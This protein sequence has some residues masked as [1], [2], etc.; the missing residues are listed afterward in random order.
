LN[1][2]F[3]VFPV[4]A[5]E[6]VF[7]QV[8]GTNIISYELYDLS[9]KI[10]MSQTSIDLPVVEMNT[11]DLS[12][13]VYITT[14]D[15]YTL[16]DGP[17]I[18]LTNDLHK[19][20]KFCIQQAN[21]PSLVMKS[22]ME[23]IEYNNQINERIYEI[24]K[25]LE[26]EEEKLASKL[27]G[28]TTSGNGSKK[29]GKHKSKIANKIIDKTDDKKISKMK[30][31]IGTLKS[32]IKNTTIDDIFVPNKQAHLNK[33][34]IGLNTSRAFASD[35]DEDTMISI[36]SL[37]NVDDSWKILLLLGIG[38]FAE[39]KSIDYSE[40]MKK[41][42]DQQKLYLIIAYSDYIYGTNYQFCHSYLSKDLLLTQEKIIQAMGRVGRNNIQQDY[43]IRLDR[44]SVV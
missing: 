36:M 31:D 13:G 5:N 2:N 4:P 16:T 19:I 18:Y 1:S 35:I 8:N 3:V 43:S 10:V 17:T 9:G 39:H 7:V 42:A 29:D 14:K 40:I 27:T 21:I 30:D 34:A 6:K 38:V 12:S 11:S 24:E 15:A 28:D 23:K 20:T 25:E 44:K 33:W 37:H 32:M 41:L 26:F 22:I